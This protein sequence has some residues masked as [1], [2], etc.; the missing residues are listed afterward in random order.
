MINWIRAGFLLIILVMLDVGLISLSG[1]FRAT[2]SPKVEVT[3]YLTGLTL[4]GTVLTYV[5]M[6][7]WW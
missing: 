6:R 3:T 2:S 7:L 1:Y 5:I 4:I